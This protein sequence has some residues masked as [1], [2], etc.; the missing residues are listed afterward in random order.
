MLARYRLL[1]ET[2]IAIPESQFNKLKRKHLIKVFI[3]AEIGR[4]PG[5]SIWLIRLKH[6]LTDSIALS[7]GEGHNDA[8]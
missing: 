2:H 4:Y 3:S 5:T 6:W 8:A 1:G 7:R